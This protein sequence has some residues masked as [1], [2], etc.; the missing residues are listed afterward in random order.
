MQL[1]RGRLRF[2]RVFA[3]LGCIFA[4]TLDRALMIQATLLLLLPFVAPVDLLEL[5]EVAFSIL[6][7][8]VMVL[9][10]TVVRFLTPFEARAATQR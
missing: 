7:V 5:D 8:I 2:L 9:K 10:V 6:S 3:R 1:D 4:E